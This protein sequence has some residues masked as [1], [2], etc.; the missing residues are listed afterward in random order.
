[1]GFANLSQ[2]IR[3]ADSAQQGDRK[4]YPEEELPRILTMCSYIHQCYNRESTWAGCGA[5]S[6]SSQA[7]SSEVGI[8]ECATLLWSLEVPNACIE[9]RMGKGEKPAPLKSTTSSGLGLILIDQVAAP[10]HTTAS[11]R[12]NLHRA[13]A[14]TTSVPRRKRRRNLLNIVRKKAWAV[15][16]LGVLELNFAET[17]REVELFSVDDWRPYSADEVRREYVRKNGHLFGDAT[18][19]LVHCIVRPIFPSTAGAHEFPSGQAWWRSRTTPTLKPFPC[20]PRSSPSSPIAACARSR[21][22]SSASPG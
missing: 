5:Y 10:P 2:F 13:M 9:K 1:M 12:L 14:P 15:T 17:T 11:H 21:S 18:P 6:V 22:S 7:P 20:P 8:E 3:D 19:R 4:A 16:S